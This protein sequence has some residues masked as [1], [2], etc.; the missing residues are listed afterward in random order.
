V[1]KGVASGQVILVIAIV[2]L[3]GAVVA[4]AQQEAKP[5]TIGVSAIIE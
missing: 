3:A 5:V 4:P 1:P 2:L